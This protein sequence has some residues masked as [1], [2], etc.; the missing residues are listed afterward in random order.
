M[1]LFEKTQELKKLKEDMI[2]TNTEILEILNGFLLQYQIKLIR[3]GYLGRQEEQKEEI[4]IYYPEL[5]VPAG[6]SKED[7]RYFRNMANVIEHQYALVNEK[8]KIIVNEKAI[9]ISRITKRDENKNEVAILKLKSSYIIDESIRYKFEI[10][11]ESFQLSR[12]FSFEDML[13][14][15]LGEQHVDYSD[16]NAA[17]NEKSEK[18]YKKFLESLD[19]KKEKIIPLKNIIKYKERENQI[20]LP[21]ITVHFE[22]IQ[23]ELDKYHMIW[24]ESP[25][26]D[27]DVG[28]A[29]ANVKY[30]IK[31]KVVTTKNEQLLCE[32]VF[33]YQEE[34]SKSKYQ[35]GCTLSEIFKLFK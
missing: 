5:T 35:N 15:L 27:V 31:L 2:Q 21:V 12:N 32:K 26:A 16:P 10:E 1:E 34:K 19:V 28:I 13:E 11:G 24:L 18:D 3:A 7:E 29:D 22:V 8:G 33:E 9:F 25:K 23:S 4:A 14:Q 6:F 17:F 30:S 20:L